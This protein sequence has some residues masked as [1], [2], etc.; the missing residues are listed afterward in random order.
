MYTPE[1]G[2]DE[3]ALPMC[4]QLPVIWRRL[5]R[6]LGLGRPASVTAHNE[7]VL[8]LQIAFQAI[9]MSGAM[10]FASVFLVRLGAP[11]WLVGL[12]T[13]LPALVTI[14]AV[15][16]V[17]AFVRRQR[18]LVAV[19]NWGRLIFRSVIASFALLPFL[20]LAV[21]P[22][23]L[24]GAR[25]LLGIPSAAINVAFTTLLGQATTPQ[26][27]PRMLSTRLA[28]HGLVAAVVGFLAGQWL[29]AVRYPL[30]YQLLFLSAPVACLGNIY[31]L[32]HFKLPKAPEEQAEKEDR[33]GL[34]ETWHLI[35]SAPRFRSFS[36][37]AFVFRLGT[38]MPMALYAI[39]RV[40]T[41]GASDAWIGILLTVQRFLSVISYLVLSR[42]LTRK[43]YRRWLWVT[44]VGV[45][46]YP[47][48][49]AIAQSPEMLLIP[50]VIGGLFGA[51][52]TIFLSNTLFH[53]S[54]EAERP[55][56]VAANTF[57]ANVTAFAAPMLGTVL[58]DAAGIRL[59]L[60][61]AGAVR[62]IGALA[63]WRLRVG[64][65]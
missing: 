64:M 14:V 3:K 23:L 45:A 62:V 19:V 53:V 65:D 7:R 33:V 18:N 52:I 49:T 35:R 47:I 9:S 31:V 44:C 36:L 57:L 39:Y 55:T 28:I 15:F 2:R 34:G 30:N 8:Y 58:A 50:A 24:V 61:V 13:S 54:P 4:V 42:L 40:R 5:V 27:R 29:D 48:T 46:L 12:Y 51:G 43:R 41:L 16:P 25:S 21:A 10:A 1:H 37:A 6:G 56:F 63:F 32:S 22:Y 20:P 38:S 60:F 17:G 59:A 26:R 11:N